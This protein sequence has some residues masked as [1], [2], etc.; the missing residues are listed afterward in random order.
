MAVTKRKFTVFLGTTLIVA[1]AASIAT[2]SIES[3]QIQQGRATLKDDETEHFLPPAEPLAPLIDETGVDAGVFTRRQETGDRGGAAIAARPAQDLG[4]CHAPESR[5]GHRHP[6]RA[7]PRFSPDGQAIATGDFSGAIRIRDATTG[8][9]KAVAVGHTMGINGLAFSADSNWLVSAG[10]DQTVKLWNAKNLTDPKVF[11]G[12]TGM[13]FSAAFFQHGQAFVTGSFDKTAIIWD[14]GNG[15]AKVKLRGHSHAVE[16]V[17]V[18]PDDKLVAT[19][20]WDQDYSPVECG[21]R[22]GNRQ[23]G[24]SRRLRPGSCLFSR[25]QNAGQRRRR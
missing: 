23:T 22:R 2:Y 7:D 6:G 10:L 20:S 24:G 15:E 11:V 14:L 5:R 12:H 1:A 21:N 4:H 13:V 19:A 9:E 25:R 8:A 3:G 16:A 18:S 17:A